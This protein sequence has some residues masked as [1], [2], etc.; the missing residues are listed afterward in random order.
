MTDRVLILNQI[1]NF[2][3]I[4]LVNIWEEAIFLDSK[5]LN[6]YQLN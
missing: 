6:L 3:M 1:Y 5:R 2:K 4:L